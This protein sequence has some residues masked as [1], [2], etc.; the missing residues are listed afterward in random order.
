MELQG[1]NLL[2]VIGAASFLGPKRLNPGAGVAKYLFSRVLLVKAQPYLL[3]LGAVVAVVAPSPGLVPKRPPSEAA[4][5]GA[6]AVVEVVAGVGDGVDVPAGLPKMLPPPPNKPAPGAVP[7]VAGAGCAA[8]PGAGAV[9]LPI[10]LGGRPNRLPVPGAGV[11]ELPVVEG[12]ERKVTNLAND[13]NH[14]ITT[15]LS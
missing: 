9:V 15:H 13:C 2:V 7:L 4:T 10:G 11:A 3:K 8:N 6:V 5:G 1:D 12:A 14:L